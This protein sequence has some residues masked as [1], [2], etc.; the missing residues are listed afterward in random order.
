MIFLDMVYKTIGMNNNK[1]TCVR[2]PNIIHIFYKAY[3]FYNFKNSAFMNVIM[4]HD[5]QMV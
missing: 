5:N 4:D 3:H 2:H 1:I